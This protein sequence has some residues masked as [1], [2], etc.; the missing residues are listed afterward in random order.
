MSDIR[1]QPQLD[2]A[3]QYTQQLQCSLEEAQRQLQA[4]EGV[5]S[6]QQHQLTV[7]EQELARERTQHVM[8]AAREEQVTAALLAAQ[9]QLSIAMSSAHINRQALHSTCAE[10]GFLQ[11]QL[12]AATQEAVK[13]QAAAGAVRREMASTQAQLQ[14]QRQATGA[15]QM[16]SAAKTFACARL[17]AELNNLRTELRELQ[18]QHQ[19]ATAAANLIITGLSQAHAQ[20]MSEHDAALQA[21]ADEH[22]KHRATR[23]ALAANAQELQA[24]RA[25]HSSCDAK[26]SGASKTRKRQQLKASTALA[27]Q[28]QTLDTVT[29][30]MQRNKKTAARALTIAAANHFKAARAAAICNRLQQRVDQ[31]RMQRDAGAALVDNLSTQLQQECSI[32]AALRQVLQQDS[33]P[34]SCTTQYP[35]AAYPTVLS[36]PMASYPTDADTHYSS[37]APDP[38]TPARGTLS[39]VHTAPGALSALTLAR[40]WGSGISLVTPCGSKGGSSSSSSNS[41]RDAS[42]GGLNVDCGS[43]SAGR[44]QAAAAGGS[45]VVVRKVGA[46]LAACAGHGDDT[47]VWFDAEEID[48]AAAV[49]Q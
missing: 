3:G 27:A 17:T 49:W 33:K 43:A 25:E 11:G 40:E 13:Q 4:G 41:S 9:Q 6:V 15:A 37:N 26:L 19:T 39:R 23:A 5:S 36:S 29:Q 45:A 34:N 1:P 8:T 14:Q 42:S 28:Q 47:D 7:L 38:A 21:C 2:E 48:C 32:A 20:L 12:H 22:L 46:S 30:R 44:W 31:L 18:Q 10:V 16:A 35:S 24:S